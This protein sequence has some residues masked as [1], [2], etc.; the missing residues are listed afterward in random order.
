MRPSNGRS[1]VWTSGQDRLA[2]NRGITP[3]DRHGDQRKGGNRLGLPVLA[4]LKIVL[5]Q[6]RTN[7]P[8]ESLARTSTL[9]IGPSGTRALRS[10]GRRSPARRARRRKTA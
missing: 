3:I 7:R 6:T 4:D 10:G 9:D 1:L 8:S 2:R 5:L